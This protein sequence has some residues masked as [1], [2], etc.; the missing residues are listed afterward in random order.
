MEIFV[1]RKGCEVVEEGFSVGDLPG[2]LADKTN[3]IWVDLMG[4][5]PEQVS[6]V[7]YHRFCA[8]R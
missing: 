4:E 7:R 3:V 6:Q 1:Y 5:T 2:L 8:V